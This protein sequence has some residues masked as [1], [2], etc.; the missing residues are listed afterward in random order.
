MSIVVTGATGHLGRLI[1]DSLLAPGRTRR[2]DRG[3]RPRH[4]PPRRP[5]RARG[6]HPAGRLRR[7][8]V[9]AGRVRRRRE[10]DVRL[11]QRGRPRVAQ[12]HNVDHRR[13]GDRRRA[14]RLHQHRQGRHLRP[15]PRRRAPGHRGG[16]PAPPACRTSCCATAGTWRTTPASSRRTA[17]TALA[18]A[19]GDGRVS[20]ATRADYAEAAAAVLTTEGPHRPGLRAGRRAFTLAELAAEVSRQTGAEVALHRP[21]GGEVHR[22]A[23]RGRRARAVRGLIADGDRGQARG[24]LYSGRRRPGHPARPRADHPRRGDP[25]RAVT[26]RRRRPDPRARGGGADRPAA[27]ARCARSFTRSSTSAST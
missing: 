11:R 12:H 15:A 5:G 19:A 21:A 9:A 7:P 4:R 25:R 27:Q 1:V 17:S 14:G 24:E 3:A 20:A 18:G 13:Q 26:T 16:D 8:R 6:G 23:R 2:P 22:A 10:A